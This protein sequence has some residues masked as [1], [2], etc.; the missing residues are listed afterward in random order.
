MLCSL[1]TSLSQFKR[2]YGDVITR[3]RDRGASDE[4]KEL[5][6]ERSQ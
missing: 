6:H 5:G 1:A 3:S 2:V 4:D